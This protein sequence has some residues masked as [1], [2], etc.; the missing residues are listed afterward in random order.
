MRDQY[1]G[2]IKTP[3][4]WWLST[5][6]KV[7]DAWDWPDTPIRDAVLSVARDAGVLHELGPGSMTSAE[8]MAAAVRVL[9]GDVTAE[10]SLV[11]F[12]PHTQRGRDFLTGTGEFA[13]D[14]E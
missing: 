7:F 11:G 14:G 6:R 1:A 12:E 4:S 10:D 8:A 9:G 5:S 2:L 13:P 3:D